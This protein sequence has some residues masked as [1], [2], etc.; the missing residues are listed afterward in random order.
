MNY[1]GQT[2]IDLQVCKAC[3]IRLDCRFIPKKV[4]PMAARIEGI[5]RTL[6]PVHQTQPGIDGYVDLSRDKRSLQLAY[7]DKRKGRC[8]VQMSDTVFTDEGRSINIPIVTSGSLRG[9]ARRAAARTM[10]N[11]IN[12]PIRAELFQVISAGAHHRRDLGGELSADMLQLARSNPFVGLFGGGGS[13]IHSAFTMTDLRPVTQDTAFLFPP[14]VAD[15]KVTGATIKED[16]DGDESAT[17]TL[18][19]NLMRI[20][21]TIRRDPML[22]GEGVEYVHNHDEVYA[23]RMAEMLASKAAKAKGSND[24]AADAVDENVDSDINLKMMSYVQAIVPGVPLFFSARMR[25]WAS[26]EHT[27]L[28]LLAL[29]EIVNAQAMGGASRR[30]FGRFDADLRLYDDGLEAPAAVFHPRDDEGQVLYR[31]TDIAQGYVDGALA[32]LAEV[33]VPELE[34][35]LITTKVKAKEAKGKG[36]AKAEAA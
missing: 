36:K 30:G 20:Y 29:G 15:R 10:L 31:F 5:I 8:Q 19:P 27:G 13:S 33:T 1:G 28:L 17:R 9:I 22:A 4:V 25:S 21:P 23:E 7:S 6:S 26:T 32:A 12:Q 16:P 3:L 24:D 18:P 14:W 35:L 11:I 34:D 2:A